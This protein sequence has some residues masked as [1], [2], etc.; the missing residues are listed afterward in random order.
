M[1]FFV[2][3]IHEL[4][5]FDATILKRFHFILYQVWT[6]R[7]DEIRGVCTGYILAFDRHWNLIMSDVDET[8]ILPKNLKTIPLGPQFEVSEKTLEVSSAS[9]S[10]GEHSGEHSSK[11]K[12]T[13]SSTVSADVPPPP[14]SGRSH[15]KRGVK[16]VEL[17]QRHVNQI[18]VR[19][20]NVAFISISSN[21]LNC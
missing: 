13:H 5:F 2:F 19:G 16:Q 20:D 14:P 10:R 17:K 1:I 21:S 9:C 12:K 7:A 6:R 11:S 4:R 3:K 18:F 15:R 8:Y